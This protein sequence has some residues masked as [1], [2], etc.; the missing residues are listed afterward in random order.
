M[1][2]EPQSL[3]GRHAVVTGAGQGIGAAIAEILAEQ[4]TRVSL[5]GRT[6]EPLEALAAKLPRAQPIVCDVTSEDSVRQAFTQAWEQAGAPAVLV[7]N[8]GAAA[9]AP[10]MKT[11]MAQWRWM[12]DVNLIGCVLCTQQVLPAMAEAGYGRVV[13]IASTAALKGYAYVSAY[14]ASKHAVLGLTRTLAL[15]YARKGVTVNAV[16]PGYTNTGMMQQTIQNIMDKT[17][18]GEEAAYRELTRMNPQARLIEPR[19]VA[20]SVLGLCRPGTD[21]ITGQAI[22]VSGGET[23]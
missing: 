22:S 4:G 9:S 8:A 15:E 19:E 16:C 18:R 23:M 21:S 13:N 6:R 5:M 17:G 3:A 7:N 12:L 2:Q 14:C 1:A 20:A 11:E 10:F